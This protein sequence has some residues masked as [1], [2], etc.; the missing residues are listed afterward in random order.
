MKIA[1]GNSMMAPAASWNE[2]C[3]L[4]K[5]AGFDGVEMWI[6][7]PGFT[8]ESTDDD[9]KALADGIGEAGLE[10]SSVASTLGWQFPICSPDDDVFAEAQ[11]IARRQIE[12]ANLFGT[13]AIL[14]VTGRA[15]PQIYQL[16][17]LERIVSGFKALADVAQETG[18]RIG[19]ETCPRLSKNL[20]TPFECVG[21]LEAVGSEAVGIYLDTANVCYSGYPEHFVRALGDDV[22]RIHFKD[23][24]EDGRSAYPGGGTL[25]F[26]PVVAECRACDYDSWA[27]M[28]YGPPPGEKHSFELMR[29]AAA[30]TRAVLDSGQI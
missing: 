25:D 19:A 15:D 22:V 9:V 27:I 21:F 6:G 18:V 3:R 8:M 30:S 29:K 26:A 20:M 17:G 23:L 5:E 12:T 14:L 4:A 28:E 13:D 16:E 24:T 10:V 2:Q 11:R 1:V 7:S